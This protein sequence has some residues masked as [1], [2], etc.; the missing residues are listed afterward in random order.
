MIY[1]AVVTSVAVLVIAVIMIFVVPTF[2][3]M[4]SGMLCYGG[5]PSHV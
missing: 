3:K 5:H 2:E 4:F 1:P